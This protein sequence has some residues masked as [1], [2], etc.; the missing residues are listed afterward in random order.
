MCGIAGTV[1][2]A[3]SRVPEL[4]EVRRMV[5]ILAHRGPDDAGLYHSEGGLLPAADAPL[6][7]SLSARWDVPRGAVLGHRRLS[8]I[9]LSSGRQPLSNEDGT[10]WVVLNGEIYNFLEL[11]KDLEAR[12]HRFQTATDTECLVHL[13][14]EFGADMLSRLRGMFAFAIFDTLRQRLMLARDRIG[15][16]P[17][18]YRLHRG[19]LDFASELKALLQLRDTPRE[20]DPVSVDL[21]LTYQY[22]PHPESILKGCAKL[23]PAH[24]ALF[25]DGRL[26]VERYWQPPYE[27]AVAERTGRA[28]SPID[29]NEADCSKLLRETLTE[30]VRLR[31]RSDVPLGAFLSGGIDST[32]IAGLMQQLSSQPVHTFSI[33]FPIAKF[34]ERSFAREASQHLGTIHHEQVVEPS[35]LSILKKLVWQYDEPFS[36]SSAIPTMYLS[37]MTRQHVT[38]ALSGDGGDELFAGYDRYRAVRIGGWFDRLPRPLQKILTSP[39]WQKLPESVEQRSFLRR[40]KRLLEALGQSPERRYLRW[41]SIFDSRRRPELLHP[42]LVARLNGHDA[43]DF[44]EA[45]YRE[46]PSRDFVTR[47]TCADLLTYLPCDIMTKVDIASMTYALEARCPF[48]DHH[49]VELAARLPIEMKLRGRQSKRILV[50][51]FR[52]LLPE[53]IQTRSK[54]GFGVPLGDW[55]RSELRP[56]LCDVLLDARSLN[57]GWFRPEGVQR[58]VMEHINGQSDHS[59]R[60]WNLLV[61]ELWQQTWTD[62]N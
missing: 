30:A 43:A 7:E 5:N 18:V 2:T 15:K 26:T 17:L 38:V 14:E 21:Y 10:V 58:L 3:G 28:P 25:E 42:D 29:L 20:I 48:L 19:R 39:L 34:D 36:D 45:A 8:I 12:G 56:M 32:I 46:C 16:K 4:D 13:Y 52:D 9:D 41:I 62:L 6:S 37:E 22:V 11:R 53:S 31:L 51:T 60:L 47:T 1:W 50:E 57:R 23:P 49:V 33:G 44:I 27:P 35:A 59:Y 54:M 55:F 61:F 24:Y 40:L